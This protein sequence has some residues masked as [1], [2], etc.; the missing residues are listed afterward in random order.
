MIPREIL[1]QKFKIFILLSLFI[2]FIEIFGGI[3]TNSLALLSDAGHVFIDLIALL[4]AY[5]S[6]ILS[7]RIPT[8]KFSFG[9]YRIEIISAIVNGIVLILITLYIFYHSY[10]RFLSP[11]S[12]KGFEMVVISVI[13][14]L[15]N[16]YVVIK[17]QGYEKENLNIRGAYLHV[18][19]DTLSSIGVVIS[20]ILIIITGNYIFDPIISV[21]IGLFIL[22]SSLKL[23]RESTYILMETTPPNI[24]LGK[25]IK[26]VQKIK[27]VKEMHDLHVWSLSSDIF[28]LSSH[29]VIDAENTKSMN[30]IISNINEMI[31]SKYRI[32]HSVIQSEC[33]KCVDENH[34]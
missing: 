16:F 26:D 7:K 21:M 33:E 9:Y 19:T 3:F 25:L 4:L 23:I 6:I 10:V 14:L 13:G 5:F 30:E 32:T 34:H 28:A 1:Q 11:Q 20:G 27:G 31:K 8:R 15:G 24:D 17:M 2:L 18:L 12:I 29:I 22:I